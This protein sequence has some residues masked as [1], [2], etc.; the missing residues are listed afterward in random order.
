MNHAFSQSG[1]LIQLWL[2]SRIR[3]PYRLS[4]SLWPSRV[5]IPLAWS[6]TVFFA[7]VIA[8]V[9]AFGATGSR[10]HDLPDEETLIDGFF[11]IV[12]VP[13]VFLAV[14]WYVAS[15][16]LDTARRQEY[17]FLNSLPL[18]G[19][20]MHRLFLLSGTSRLWWFP[21]GVLVL[22]S[23]LP[24]YSPV[25]FLIRLIIIIL[26]AYLT[27]QIAGISFHLFISR[28]RAGQNFSAYP[29]RSHPL[30]QL[31]LTAGII[32][33]AVV[34]ILHPVQISGRNFWFALGGVALVGTGFF[35]V[36]GK[37]FETWR[38]SNVILRSTALHAGTTGFGYQSMSRILG[39]RTIPGMSNPLLLKNVVRSSR[40]GAFV[41]RLVLAVLFITV[42]WLVAMNNDAIGDSVVI[43]KGMFSLYAFFF[44]LG[45]MNR[46]GSEEEPVALLYSLPVT[47]AEL[48]LSALVPTIV[49]LMS[50]LVPLTLLV[51]IAGGGF[52][53]TVDFVWSSFAVCLLFSVIGVSLAVGHYPRRNEALKRFLGWLLVLAVLITVLYRFRVVVIVVAT[54]LALL[55]LLRLRLYR[56]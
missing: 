32:A 53:L 11:R 27:L 3:I 56:T 38:R 40:Q 20:D 21:C 29:V 49:W 50:I 12:F 26:A 16:K 44:V 37:I 7:V 31:G 9:V 5:R 17:V 8:L 14:A 39:G 42:V 52:K 6:A 1:R 48:Y 35:F 2:R 45:M 28:T 55:P 25:P 54:L 43:V 41:S 34:C 15:L 51:V 13:I 36:S 23:T 22:L 19:R 24:R 46:L 30:I 18:S 33:V 47:R 4:S 10:L